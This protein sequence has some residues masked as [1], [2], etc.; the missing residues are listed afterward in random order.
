MRAYGFRRQDHGG[1]NLDG[2]GCPCCP[3]KWCGWSPKSKARAKG[4]KKRAR[5][6]GKV[7]ARFYLGGHD[8]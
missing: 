6:L 5:R 1:I 4:H 2:K 3:P 7:S 8:E